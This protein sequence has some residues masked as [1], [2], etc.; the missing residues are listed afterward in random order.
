[1]STIRI[2][3]PPTRWEITRKAQWVARCEPFELE[4]VAPTLPE[5]HAKIRVALDE[6]F[7]IRFRTGLLPEILRDNGW[8]ADPPLPADIPRDTPNFDVPFALGDEA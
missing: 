7:R 1:M 3:G 4:V 2:D 8:V 6:Y 5:L